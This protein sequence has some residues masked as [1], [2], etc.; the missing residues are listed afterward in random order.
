MRTLT[1]CMLAF[2][3]FWTGLSQTIIHPCNKRMFES[4]VRNCRSAF[5]DSMETSGY[6]QGC[7]WPAV[8]RI[9]YDLKLCVDHWARASSCQSRGSLVDD[10]FGEVH[11]E[12]F[13]FCPQLRDPPLGTAAIF[14]APLVI[15]TLL[16]PLLCVKLVTW[17][18]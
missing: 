15:I 17:N 9:Y 6:R 16:M 7:A 5:N 1:S 14:I 13:V 10:L 2:V 4:N 11:Q 12:Y 8:K 18:T 3:F